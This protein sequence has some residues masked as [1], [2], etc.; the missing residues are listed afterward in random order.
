MPFEGPSAAPASAARSAT[1]ATVLHLCGLCDQVG[2][3]EGQAL[4]RIGRR[5][6]IRSGDQLICSTAG[7][8]IVGNLTR[9]VLEVVRS[10]G[11]GARSVGLVFPGEIVG[12]PFGPPANA[13]VRAL[14]D[15]QLCIFPRSALEQVS[16]DYPAVQRALLRCALHSLSEARRWLLIIGRQSARE[17]VVAFLLEFA[18]R[19]RAGAPSGD[20][21]DLPLKRGSIGDLLGLSMETISRQLQAL[22][23]AGLIA[24]PSRRTIELVDRPGLE[25]LVGARR[26]TLEGV[27]A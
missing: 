23:R 7:D 1:R 5:Q 19:Q 3:S 24:L 17:R 12:H 2:E 26:S 15:A 18:R 11:D 20:T 27:M 10:E 14:T 4:R 8:A 25:R 6:R 22:A 9:G 16:R 21:L 13:T